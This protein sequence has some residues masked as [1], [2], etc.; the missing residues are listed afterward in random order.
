MSNITYQITVILGYSMS[1]KTIIALST[2]GIVVGIGLVLGFIHEANLQSYRIPFIIICS[3]LIGII[4]DNNIFLHGF[5]VGLIS[6]FMTWI[7]VFILF[8]T[9]AAHNLS[10]SAIKEKYFDY[11]L[12]IY[13]ILTG[14]TMGVFIGFLSW[15]TADLKP[16]VKSIKSRLKE[17]KKSS[18]IQSA[19]YIIASV[20]SF[21]ASIYFFGIFFVS[22]AGHPPFKTPT[23]NI[24]TIIVSVVLIWVFYRLGKLFLKASYNSKS[25]D[26]SKR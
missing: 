8:S 23:N 14:V 6:E 25:A 11:F 19:F 5:F 10:E 7:I 12:L 22:C 4:F 24:L 16:Y 3:L 1:W 21:F 17:I 15:L 26:N 20:L 13:G 9:F 2:Y 18:P